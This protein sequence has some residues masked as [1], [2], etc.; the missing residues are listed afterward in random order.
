MTSYVAKIISKK[1]LGESLQ[2]KFGKEDPYFEQ[3]PATRLDG[4]PTGK[5][6]KRKK[7]LPPGISEHDGQVLTKV[8]R[9]AYRLDLSLCS[10][11]GVRFG[12]SSVIGIVPAIGDALDAFMALMV[13]KTCCQVEGGLPNTLK[14]HMLSNIGLDFAVGLVPFVGDLADAMFKANSRNALLLEQY[15]REKGKK[16]LRK[17]GQPVPAIDPSSP[18]EFDRAAREEIPPPYDAGTS[19]PAERDGHESLPSA[20]EGAKVRG[21]RGWFGRSKA[22]PHDIEMGTPQPQP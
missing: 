19:P 16:E 17:S 4:R 18:E 9:R 7:A 20:P 5:V 10:F 21:G 12:W 8:K 6:K 11:L 22:R 13:L 3:V 1:I 14:L 15:L 2:N